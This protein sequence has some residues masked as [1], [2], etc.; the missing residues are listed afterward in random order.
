MLLKYA[1]KVEFVVLGNKT[2]WT[3]RELLILN[4]APVCC[5]A[6]WEQ[7]ACI[8]ALDSKLATLAC[9]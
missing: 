4:F 9:M 1:A 6:P 5:G 3:T 2:H 7:H 8:V